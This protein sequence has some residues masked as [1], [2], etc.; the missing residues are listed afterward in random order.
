[1][2]PPALMPTPAQRR[3]TERR[4]RRSTPATPQA[5]PTQKRNGADTHMGDKQIGVSHKHGVLVTHRQAK[6]A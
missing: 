4:M 3:P 2:G 6:Q 5:D 1:M